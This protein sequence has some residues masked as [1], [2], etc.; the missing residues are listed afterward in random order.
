MEQ[1]DVYLQLL[2]IKENEIENIFWVTW[3]AK[4][5]IWL[6]HHWLCQHFIDLLHKMDQT[7][8]FQKMSMIDLKLVKPNCV[9][10]AHNLVPPFY[11][12]FM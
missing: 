12:L 9:W 6:V 4:V 3:T 8:I 5:L 10:L 1:F 7:S 2:E 11:G